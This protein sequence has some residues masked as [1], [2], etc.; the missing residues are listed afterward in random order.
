MLLAK[1]VEWCRGIIKIS[2][3][4]RMS[5]IYTLHPKW[6]M[7]IYYSLWSRRCIKLL[8]WMGVIEAQDTKAVTILWLYNKNAFGGQEWPNRWDK[9]LGPAHTAFSMRV[10]SPRPFYA[11]LWLW[12]PWISCMLISQALRPCWSQT[13]HLEL[14]MSW[15]SKTTSWSTCWHTWPL[16]KLWKLSLNSYMEDASLSLGPWPS[17]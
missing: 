5:S 16:I 11:P 6:K 7:R 12:L 17:S 2:Q 9:L 3:S 13:N 4:P 8:L 10:A 14:P 1:R 15:C